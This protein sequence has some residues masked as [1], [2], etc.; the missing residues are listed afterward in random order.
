MSILFTA[1]YYPQSPCKQ[2]KNVY[3]EGD[4]PTASFRHAHD[5]EA[6][7]IQTQ[8][9]LSWPRV[10]HEMNDNTQHH[11]HNPDKRQAVAFAGV[12]QV[13]TMHWKVP[14]TIWTDDICM[15]KENCSCRIL[16]GGGK[17][18]SVYKTLRTSCHERKGCQSDEKIQ[19]ATV[20]VEAKKDRGG[21]KQQC[22]GEQCDHIYIREWIK[23]K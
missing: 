3:H 23:S 10:S 6:L 16:S 21:Q 9:R 17:S 15:R 7:M 2:L 22:H 11:Q 12:F 5:Y 8:I 14:Q 13:S 4:K 20:S 19:H 18:T 1:K